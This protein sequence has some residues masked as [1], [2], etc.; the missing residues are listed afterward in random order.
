M[1]MYIFVGTYIPFCLHFLLIFSGVSKILP[2]LI[3]V[4]V[5]LNLQSTLEVPYTLGGKTRFFPWVLGSGVRRSRAV[6]HPFRGMATIVRWT[7]EVKV[8]S[9][10]A[11]SRT[12]ESFSGQ[13]AFS[14]C[15]RHV[16]SGQGFFVVAVPFVQYWCA[17]RVDALR[18]TIAQRGNDLVVP[19]RTT[20]S[21]V[22]PA[23]LRKNTRQVCST[24]ASQDQAQDAWQDL[25]F[26]R[27]YHARPGDSTRGNGIG[28]QSYIK[29]WLG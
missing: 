13:N 25:R 19:T 28:S 5:Q 18:M 10:Y 23:L 22:L 29:E 1:Y 21:G 6:T 15:L 3:F 4:F 9:N 20:S 26:N 27:Q 14:L 24:I 7:K 8:L 2:Y 17:E 16:L 12:A 11:G